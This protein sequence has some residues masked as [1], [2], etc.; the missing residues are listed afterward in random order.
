M[1]KTKLSIKLWWIRPS[2]TQVLPVHTT[3][4][5]EPTP[6]LAQIQLLPCYT[7]YGLH[8]TSGTLG[9]K[10]GV[11]AA[12]FV[13]IGTAHFDLIFKA[14]VQSTEAFIMSPTLVV[15]VLALFKPCDWS[16]RFMK[17]ILLVLSLVRILHLLRPGW[18]QDS[19]VQ[20]TVYKCTVV[21]NICT[22]V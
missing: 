22:A 4:S 20:C 7:M 5:M 12:W 6:H 8:H 10:Y 19:C 11:W 14:A 16:T 17:V 2:H 13:H 1:I 9:T 18:R 21:Q 3:L 15:S